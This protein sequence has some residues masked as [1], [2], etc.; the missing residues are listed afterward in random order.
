MTYIYIPG[1]GPCVE[2]APLVAVT[3]EDKIAEIRGRHV[4]AIAAAHEYLLAETEM[5]LWE[6]VELAIDSRKCRKFWYHP[7]AGGVYPE[8]PGAVMYLMVDV[9]MFDPEV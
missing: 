2:Q 5:D 6:I 1:I 3:P 7:V 8:Y 9:P 4:E